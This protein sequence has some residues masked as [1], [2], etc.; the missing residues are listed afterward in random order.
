MML[1]RPDWNPDLFEEIG[2]NEDSIAALYPALM[3]YMDYYAKCFSCD[4]QQ[5]NAGTYLRGLL[6]DLDRKNI[7]YIALRYRDENAVRT[8]QMFF[9]NS[10]WDDSLMKSLYQSRVFNTANDP[11]GMLTVDGSDHIKKG[12]SSAGVARQYCGRFGKI[13]NCQAGVYIGYSGNKGYGLLDCWIRVF[14]CRKNGL[15]TNTRLC[16]N[17]AISLTK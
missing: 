3:Q 4:A 1:N 5:A 8:L 13:E 10:P 15:T 12:S 16:E 7:E 17:L 11:E 6:S 2:L 9:K 14:I